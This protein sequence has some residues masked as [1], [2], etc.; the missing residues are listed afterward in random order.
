M[1]CIQNVKKLFFKFPNFEHVRDTLLQLYGS[2]RLQRNGNSDN[3]VFHPLHKPIE[4]LPSST[5]IHSC[6]P[7]LL[8]VLTVLANSI[9]EG[10]FHFFKPER[11][12]IFSAE[13]EKCFVLAVSFP[14][15]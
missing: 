6:L 9:F 7:V 1:I 3:D 8:S 2:S 14:T 11:W 10:M 5:E 4:F 15:F 12:S 13:Q